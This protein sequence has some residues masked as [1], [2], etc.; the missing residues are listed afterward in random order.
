MGTL[1]HVHRCKL[2][3]LFVREKKGNNPCLPLYYSQFVKNNF[4]IETIFV[5]IIFKF[6]SFI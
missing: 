3:E 4:V 1:L 5:E 6:H 2:M